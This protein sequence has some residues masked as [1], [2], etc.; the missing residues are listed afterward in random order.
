MRWHHSITN[1]WTFILFSFPLSSYC[2]W[3]SFKSVA[4]GIKWYPKLTTLV[5]LLCTIH[6]IEGDLSKV[7]PEAPFRFLLSL[8]PSPHYLI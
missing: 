5:A 8:H 6:N 7:P 1:F 4:W 3:N 2:S